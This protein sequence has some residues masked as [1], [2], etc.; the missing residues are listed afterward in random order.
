MGTVPSADA[1]VLLVPAGF[2]GFHTCQYSCNSLIGLFL[3]W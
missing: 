1:E 3:G 2:I